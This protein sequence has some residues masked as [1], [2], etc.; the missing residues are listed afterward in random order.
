MHGWLVQRI[1]VWSRGGNE[2]ASFVFIFGIS[3]VGGVL[4]PVRRAGD[5]SSLVLV[6]GM[7]IRGGTC[8]S[9]HRTFLECRK[10]T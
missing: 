10:G 1:L 3:S 6:Y 4:Q 8:K 7:D 9:R 2:Y 5:G